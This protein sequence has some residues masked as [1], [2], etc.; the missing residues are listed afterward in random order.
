MLRYAVTWNQLVYMIPGHFAHATLVTG[1]LCV[2]ICADVM[3]FF[4]F[5]FF[6]II[7]YEHNLFNVAVLIAE[8]NYY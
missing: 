2:F 8:L 7:Y 5:F 1:A 4:F 3:I 6:F